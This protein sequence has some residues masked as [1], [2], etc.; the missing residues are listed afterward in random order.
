MTDDGGQ[1]TD[2]GFLDPSS[3]VRHLSSDR[4][5]LILFI[6]RLSSDFRRPTQDEH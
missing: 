2:Q 5:K 1:R 3:V 4:S 6:R